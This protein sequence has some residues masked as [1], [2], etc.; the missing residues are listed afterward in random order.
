MS[1][2]E[3]AQKFRSHALRALPEE[4]VEPAL[5]ALWQIDAADSLSP[6]FAAIN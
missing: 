1:D 4:R 5:A 3:I 2:Q 6:V